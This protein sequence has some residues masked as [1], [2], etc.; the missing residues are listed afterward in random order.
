MQYADEVDA[1]LR[2]CSRLAK[3][4]PSSRRLKEKKYEAKFR[5]E[6]ADKKAELDKTY[7]V[8]LKYMGIVLLI[9]AVGFGFFFIMSAIR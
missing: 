3:L 1:E 2:A 9:E 5:K 8:V 4:T 6:E 7:K